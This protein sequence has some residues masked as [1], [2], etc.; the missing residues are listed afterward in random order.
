MVLTF[1]LFLA[2]FLFLNFQANRIPFQ[3]DELD[4][5]EWAVLFDLA[6]RGNF[7]DPM[8]QV[9]PGIDQPPLAFVLFGLALRLSGHENIKEYLD[10]INFSSAV[11]TEPR[12]R[13][14]LVAGVQFPNGI[15]SEDGSSSF[16][17]G[18]IRE[19]RKLN[20]I[21]A[22]GSV[23]FSFFIG[24]K[25]GGWFFGVISASLMVVNPLFYQSG[26]EA[27]GDGVMLFF[28]I[29]AMFLSLYLFRNLGNLSKVFLITTLMGIIVGLSTAA[30]LNG[31]MVLI[32]LWIAGVANLLFQKAIGFSKLRK[33]L[34]H[35]LLGLMTVSL[36]SFL[37]F[38]VFTP[39]TW[40]NPLNRSVV[41]VRHRLNTLETQK[42]LFPDQA[43]LSVNEK[44][45]V[46]YNNIFHR[47]SNYSLLSSLSEF[48]FFVFI[49]G[50]L[51]FLFKSYKLIQSF[52]ESNDEFMMFIWVSVMLSLVVLLN[53]LD[54]ER[55]YLPVIPGLVLVQSAAIFFIITLIV[56]WLKNHIGIRIR[57]W[58]K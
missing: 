56:N 38:V 21:F 26:I 15:N 48:W 2:F 49:L 57:V 34:I 32:V 44:I 7:Q 35:T 37:V 50:M 13:R 5:V 30:K 1:F 29:V 47:G 4:S 53:P 31:S 46:G 25:I 33:L 16:T 54:W 52:N 20:A 40:R 51:I 41:M 11:K 55:Y 39:F 27:R 36:I 43:L 45:S 6:L 19:V 8:W 14:S 9:Y 17:L 58:D 22:L 12:G 3:D 42:R 28:L 23:I 24:R 10:S 18:L